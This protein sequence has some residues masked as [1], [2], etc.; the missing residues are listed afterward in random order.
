MTDSA[1]R[2]RATRPLRQLD[3]LEH[4]GPVARRSTR[5]FTSASSCSTDRLGGDVLDLEHVDQP[6]ELLGR[7]LDRDVVAV[8][9]D[10]HPA[11]ARAVGPADGQRVDVEVAGPH[12]ATRRGSG[13]RA[14]RRRSRRGVWRRVSPPPGRARGGGAAWAGAPARCRRRRPFEL[15]SALIR[16]PRPLLDQVGQAL[17]GRHHREDVLLLGDLEPDERRAVDRLGDP[18]RVVDLGRASTP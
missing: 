17:A 10:R 11:D 2:R 1:A 12:Q 8:E 18:D 4:L 15:G 14:C 7:L 6:V 5:T 9:A 16:P 3:E 13:R